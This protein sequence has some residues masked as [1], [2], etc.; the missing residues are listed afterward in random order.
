[1]IDRG[2]EGEKNRS[3]LGKANIILTRQTVRVTEKKNVNNTDT[4]TGAG[5]DKLRSS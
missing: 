5:I 4:Q 3:D 1:M 2:C